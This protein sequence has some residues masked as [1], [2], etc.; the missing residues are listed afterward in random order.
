MPRNSTLQPLCVEQ[1]VIIDTFWCQIKLTITVDLNLTYIICIHCALWNA[2]AKSQ[3]C[4][5][6]HLHV[7]EAHICNV[8]GGRADSSYF[9]WN[10]LLVPLW[11]RSCDKQATNNANFSSG[12]NR[13]PNSSTCNPKI[14]KL[15]ICRQQSNFKK[16]ATLRLLFV[17]CVNLLHSCSFMVYYYESL[18]IG[19]FLLL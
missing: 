12:V 4:N 8:H 11:S 13:F 2:S 19:V 16:R 18:S 3:G 5:E 14:G 1:V 10:E 9:I 15:Q 17:I 7:T 6:T